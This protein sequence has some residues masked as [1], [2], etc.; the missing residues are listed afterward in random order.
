MLASFSLS[1]QSPAGLEAGN[2]QRHL[3]VA[4]HVGEGKHPLQPRLL[5]LLNL[6]RKKVEKR[7]SRSQCRGTGSLKDW[8]LIM[9]LAECLPSPR[10]LP[11]HISGS[12]GRTGRYNRKYVKPSTLFKKEKVNRGGKNHA[13]RGNGS[14]WHLPLQQMENCSLTPVQMSNCTL[15]ASLLCQVQVPTKN[16]Q[17]PL[18]RIW[19]HN[20]RGK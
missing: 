10:T 15:K 19:S 9:R 18:S 2:T 16:G 11:P 5:F 7:L 4:F 14:V 8:D 13:G 1:T 20:L 12:L 6:S 3:P 17:L